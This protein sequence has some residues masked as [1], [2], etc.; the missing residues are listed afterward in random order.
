[1]LVD[2][3]SSVTLLHERVWNDIAGGKKLNASQCPVMAVNGESLSLCGQTRLTLW[4][5]DMLEAILP[6]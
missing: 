4:W 5:A 3:G 2:T 6:L 1:M